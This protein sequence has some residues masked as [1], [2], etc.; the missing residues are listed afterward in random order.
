M[1]KVKSRGVP[2]SNVFRKMI[3]NIW[4][5]IT[6]AGGGINKGTCNHQ[7][8]KTFDRIL[9]QGKKLPNYL[10]WNFKIRISNIM[11]SCFRKM[12]KNKAT[13]SDCWS[14]KYPYSC[15]EPRVEITNVSTLRMST[16]AWSVI[17]C[18]YVP[19]WLFLVNNLPNHVLNKHPKEI[20]PHCE[21]Y[22]EG[23]IQF[24]TLMWRENEMFHI[25]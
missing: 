13:E 11:Y 22:F 17:W 7:A 20:L 24:H 16:S 23:I 21:D 10:I 14:L 19:W 3:Y 4:I 18:P 15:L 6:K 8:L 1:Q 9:Q 25:H 5:G 12:C 2:Y